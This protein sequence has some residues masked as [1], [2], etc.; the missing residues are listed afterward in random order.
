V[1]I[2]AS[3]VE[4]YT[5]TGWTGEAEDISL[6]DDATSLSTFFTMPNRDITLTATYQEVVPPTYTL[7]LLA[8]PDDIGA[9]LTGA[10]EYEEGD[11]VN[12]TASAVEGYTFTGWTGEAEDIALLDNPLVAS[13]SLTMP[14]R[15]VILTA[16]Y[17]QQTNDTYTVTFFV[18]NP[19]NSPIVGANISITGSGNLTTDASGTA[20]IQLPNGNYSFTVTASGYGNYSDVFT[21]VDAS[22]NVLVILTPVGVETNALSTLKV[23]PNPFKNS[24]TINN[25]SRVSHLIVTNITGQQVMDMQ[26]SGFERTTISN[27]GLPKGVYLMIFQTENGERVI[28]KMIKE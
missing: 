25:A 26:L 14:T 21:I 22:R 1:N 3:A 11:E 6:L 4:G 8:D 5:F 7:T 17:E 13:T 10:G 15:L 18:R 23:F 12:I 16:K 27:D 20:I 19:E 24:I 9:V 28:K 2:T